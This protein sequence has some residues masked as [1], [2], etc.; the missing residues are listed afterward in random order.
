VSQSVGCGKQ[1]GNAILSLCNQRPTYPLLRIAFAI[2]VGAGARWNS[3]PGRE[4][5]GLI[6]IPECAADLGSLNQLGTVLPAKAGI[7]NYDVHDLEPVQVSQRLICTLD[8]GLDGI[9]EAGL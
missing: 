2:A 6:V 8:R 7:H 4:A 5:Q 9:I 3:S 1:E